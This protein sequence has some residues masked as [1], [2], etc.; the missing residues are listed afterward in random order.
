LVPAPHRQRPADDKRPANGRLHGHPH[1]LEPLARQ[2]VRHLPQVALAVHQLQQAEV[3]VQPLAKQAPPPGRKV[4]PFFQV[5]ELDEPVAIGKGVV[6]DKPLHKPLEI[7][8]VERSKL[9]QTMAE[10]K[11]KRSLKLPIKP[12]P[13]GTPA[14]LVAQLLGRSLQFSP[15]LRT[16]QAT[17]TS[18]RLPR[19]LF[20]MIT[21]AA[22]P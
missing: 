19:R 7:G 17:G 1:A 2:E 9:P 14:Q 12:R 10:V 5:K 8:L 6:V 4:R 16:A 11:V 18:R 13:A 3:R 15:A 20:K 22:P 21:G